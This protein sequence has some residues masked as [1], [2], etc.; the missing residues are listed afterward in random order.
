MNNS[1][2][3]EKIATQG[4]TLCSN[5]D[6]RL[7]TLPAFPLPRAFEKASCRQVFLMLEDLE[8]P[9]KSEVAYLNVLLNLQFQIISFWQ[10]FPSTSTFFQCQGTN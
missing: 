3:F 5:L 2:T 8:M 9:I 1:K 4:I 10:Y 7:R 6:T